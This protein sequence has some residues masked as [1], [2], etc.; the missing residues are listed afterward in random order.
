[1][2][3]IYAEA[4]C[5]VSHSRSFGSW[6]RRHWYDVIT[7]DTTFSPKLWGQNVDEKSRITRYDVN[8]FDMTI[9][10]MS[11]SQSEDMNSFK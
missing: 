9:S 3:D 2:K 8:R 4:I 11:V 7:C 5:V 6:C 1:M 10:Y